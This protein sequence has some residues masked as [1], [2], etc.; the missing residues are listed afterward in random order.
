MAAGLRRPNPPRATGVLEIVVAREWMADLWVP[1]RKAR[2]C[3]FA[4]VIRL[5]KGEVHMWRPMDGGGSRGALQWMSDA[6]RC[7]RLG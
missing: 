3:W 1:A 7:T 2:K 6:R 4:S 5:R